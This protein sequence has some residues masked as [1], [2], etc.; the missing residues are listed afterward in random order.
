[1][2]FGLLPLFFYFHCVSALIRLN[3]AFLAFFQ[4]LFRNFSANFSQIFSKLQFSCYRYFLS[5]LRNVVSKLTTYLGCFNCSPHASV[6]RKKHTLVSCFVRLVMFRPLCIIYSCH[7]IRLVDCFSIYFFVF[8]L[9][10]LTAFTY[11]LT[12]GG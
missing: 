1:M 8:E 6:S 9:L 12:A 2:L 7:I 10:H 11:I 3:F 4:L 5:S